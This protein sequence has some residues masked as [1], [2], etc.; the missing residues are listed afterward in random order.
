M[1]SLLISTAGERVLQT[2]QALVDIIN[3]A[4]CAP[5][6]IWDR[7]LPIFSPL[8]TDNVTLTFL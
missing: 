3:F 5:C 7:Q 8:F 1:F 2:G 6:I 4:Y